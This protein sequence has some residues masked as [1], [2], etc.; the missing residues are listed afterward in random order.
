MY[1]MI[2]D[3]CLYKTVLQIVQKQL[4][5]WNLDSICFN[6]HRQKIMKY[7]R[8]THYEEK[9][10]PISTTNRFLYAVLFVYFIHS[11]LL[12]DNNHETK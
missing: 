6:G 11:F 1:T 2:N 12:T 7:S 8:L 4:L 9:N 5:F 10:R 3:I